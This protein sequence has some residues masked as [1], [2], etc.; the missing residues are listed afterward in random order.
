MKELEIKD[1]II[2]PMEP[3]DVDEASAI[4]AAV[5][6]MP[7]KSAD[8]LEMIEAPYAH[9][10][11]AKDGVSSKIVGILG[12][13]DI[14]GEGEITNVAV[15]PEYR[16]QKVA[17]ALMNQAM[18]KCKELGIKDVTLEV[19]VS[20]EPAIALYESFDFCGEGIRP[21]FYEKPSEDALIMWRRK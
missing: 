14:A 13:R 9:Y 3:E 21:G 18:A 11:F 16:R 15:V 8:F 19:R 10:Y 20:N 17:K 12:L 2:R 7:W 6:S 1:L 5:F 4:E